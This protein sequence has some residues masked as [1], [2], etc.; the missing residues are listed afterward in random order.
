MKKFLWLIFFSLLFV[1]PI[2]AKVYY[3]EYSDF[4]DFQEERVDPTDVIDVKKES[5]YLWYKNNEVLNDYELYNSNDNF[6]DDCYFTDYSPWMNEK[7][8]NE[9][10]ISEERIKYDYILSKEIRYIHLYNLQG[11]YGA[12][13]ITELSVKYDNI[14]INYTYT[15]DGCWENFGDYINNG[16]YD[17]NKSYID[18]GGSLIID[19]GKNISYSFN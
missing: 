9:G 5:R 12:F 11:S 16:I 4:S 17:E 15:C 18:N 19:L 14:P 1:S 3:S 13:R 10:Y 6:S 2:K 7:I 8:E